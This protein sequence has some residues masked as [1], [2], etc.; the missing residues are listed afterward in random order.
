MILIT[1]T[2]VGFDPLT[3]AGTNP[4]CVRDAVCM[5]TMDF[6]IFWPGVTTAIAAIIDSTSRWLNFEIRH[7]S[8]YYCIIFLRR[9]VTVLFNYFTRRGNGSWNRCV[10]SE[11]VSKKGGKKSFD[12]RFTPRIEFHAELTLTYSTTLTYVWQTSTRSLWVYWKKK[13]YQREKERT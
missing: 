13:K 7:L 6:V 9:F 8:K 12:S 2:I 10:R 4:C 3:S 5:L 1:P 11:P